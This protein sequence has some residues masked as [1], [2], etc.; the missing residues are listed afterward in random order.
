MAI[1]AANPC[2]GPDPLAIVDRLTT[3]ATAAIAD[4]RADIER[5]PSSLRSLTLELTVRPDG[6]LGDAIAFLERRKRVG[7]RGLLDHPAVRAV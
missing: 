7:E 4:I 2:G 6:D 1:E 3:A 5:D